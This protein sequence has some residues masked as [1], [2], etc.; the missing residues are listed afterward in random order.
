MVFTDMLACLDSYPDASS[1]TAVDQCARLAAALGD[2]VCAV[3]AH[4][5]IPL[6]SNLIANLLLDLSDV[7]R[8]EEARSLQNAQSV[9]Q[10][11]V[12]SAS[13]AG[14]T[15]PTTMILHADLQDTN[16]QIVRIARARSLCLIPQER[17]DDGQASLA[18]AAI[19]GSGRPVVIFAAG[20]QAVVRGG[21]DTVVIAWDGGRAAAR[22][23]ADAMPVLSRAGEVRI[24]SVLND[25]PSVSAGSATDLVRHLALSG[26]AAALDEIDGRDQEIGQCLTGYAQDRGAD[27]LVTGAFGHSRAR[28]FILGGATQSLL[29][30]PIVPVFMSH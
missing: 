30:A 12:R 24:V 9:L 11:F 26:I 18:E 13:V 28:E 7:A 23:V 5:R 17:F 29:R 3:A 8:Q 1:Q 6:K 10:R 27:L 19:F 14:L 20:D 4:V 25:K 2:G 21:L 22:A 15:A 16:D